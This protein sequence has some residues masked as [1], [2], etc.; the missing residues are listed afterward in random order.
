MYFKQKQCHPCGYCK[1]DHTLLSLCHGWSLHW[2]VLCLWIEAGAGVGRAP[3]SGQH[4]VFWWWWCQDVLRGQPGTDPDLERLCYRQT[5]KTRSDSV[6]IWPWRS[7]IQ[8]RCI[9]F[10][11]TEGICCLWTAECFIICHPRN[12]AGL[13]SEQGCWGSRNQG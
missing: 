9:S 12:S 5:F 8:T 3:R 7:L 10:A 1:Q 13:D 2:L 11:L 4:L 6:T